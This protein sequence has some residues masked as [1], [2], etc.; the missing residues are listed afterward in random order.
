MLTDADI[1]TRELLKGADAEFLREVLGRIDVTV[2]TTATVRS[3]FART[4]NTGMTLPKKEE[5][6]KPAETFSAKVRNLFESR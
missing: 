6:V 1:I 2:V 4:Q 5:V 3:I